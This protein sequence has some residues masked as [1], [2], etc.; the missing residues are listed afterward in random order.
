MRI[1]QRCLALVF[2]VAAT[3]LGMVSAPQAGADCTS[4]GGVTLC[5][6][7]E[8]RGSSGAPVSTGPY[9]PYPCE[10]DWLCDGSE[11]DII[12]PPDPGPPDIGFPG[13]PGNRPGRPGGGGGGGIGPR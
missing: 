12:L 10:Y 2:A 9:V 4:S 8:V 11:L 1:R 7:G 13:T 3:P 5:S 6:Q